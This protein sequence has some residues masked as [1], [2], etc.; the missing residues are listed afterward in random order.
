MSLPANNTYNAYRPIPPQVPRRHRGRAFLSLLILLLWL[1]ALGLVAF[2][3]HNIL[4]WWK[5][6]HYQP[7][8]AV[9]TLAGQDTMTGYSRK[10]FYV[11]HPQIDAKSTFSKS[12]PDNGGEQ[13]IVLG[14]YRAGENGIFLLNVNDPRLSGVLQVTAAH[15]MLHGAYERLSS[16]DRKKVDAMLIDYYNHDLH[17][18]RILNTIAAYKKSEPNDVVNEMHS[19]FGTEVAHLPA[20]LEQYYKRY[21]TDRSRIAGY[22]AQYQA[23]FTSRT[24]LISQYDSQ[25]AQLKTQINSDKSDLQSKQADI[26]SL[27]SKL[28]SQKSSGDISD[29][30]AGVPVYNDL[31][32]RYNAEVQNVKDLI[33]QYN[34]LVSA[35]NAVALE[36][37]Q[38]V[39]NLSADS[40][41]IRQ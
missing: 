38:L 39:Q 31:V 14:C 37:D 41:P 11:N 18:Q 20:G 22:A 40:V 34:Q 1:A 36:E 24:T 25:L 27:Q 19:V 28:N 17:D 21:F 23:Q 6:E 30:N 26:T 2:N 7:S 33:S 10:I 29:Y 13:T 4:D 3:R 8:A 16:S 12:C 32:N 9:A 35:R 15:E 5:L